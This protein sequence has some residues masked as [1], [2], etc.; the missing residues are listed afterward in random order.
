[1]PTNPYN[2]DLDHDT[3]REI[4]NGTAG[5]IGEEFFDML[6][7]HLA[8]AMGTTCAWVTEWI[9]DERRLRALSFWAEDRHVIDYEYHVAGTPC[10]PVI[11]KRELFH[12]PDRL[13][14][15]FPKD[16]DLSPLGA[17]SYMGVPLMDTDGHL[18][19]HL[20]ILH[21]KPLP[22][23]PVCQPSSIFLL[24]GLEQNFAD[25]AGIEISASA[26]KKCH[27]SSKA[28]KIQS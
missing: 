1:M 25:F 23:D 2:P 15:L 21:N 28:P 19:G 6:V 5:E 18:L 3:L 20:A 7:Q 22:P 12:V 10:E 26:N 4:V 24:D 13:I 14:E 8:R 17:V 27:G 11:D 9:E 16:P